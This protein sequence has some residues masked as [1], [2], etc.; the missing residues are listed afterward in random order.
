MAKYFK[1]SEF[2]CKCGCGRNTID[3]ELVRKLDRIRE[4]A[5]IP[6]VI[7]SGCRC[8]K[9]NKEAGGKEDSAHLSGLA[10]DMKAISSGTRW[11]LLDAIFTENINRIGIGK[12]FIH[13]DIEVSKPKEVVWMY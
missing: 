13:I 6:I 9:N 2:D 12:T 1:L 3:A 10:A 7:S 11:K 4:K 5:G 8:E